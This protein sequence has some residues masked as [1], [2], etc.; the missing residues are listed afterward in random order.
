M[1]NFISPKFNLLVILS[2]EFIK[3]IILKI[4]I[5][6]TNLQHNLAII[7][8]QNIQYIVLWNIQVVIPRYMNM[9]IICQMIW[10]MISPSLVPL[11]IIVWRLINHLPFALHQIIVPHNIKVNTYLNNGRYYQRKLGCLLLFT[12]MCLVMVRV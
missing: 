5:N 10:S 11:F 1:I 7:I 12:K 9:F 8:S 4:C 3:W 6:N 2:A